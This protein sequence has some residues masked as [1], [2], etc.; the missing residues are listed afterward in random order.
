MLTLMMKTDRQG[1]EQVKVGIIDVR[2]EFTPDDTDA[3]VTFCVLKRIDMLTGFFGKCGFVSEL[4]RKANAI[5]S[6]PMYQAVG[7]GPNRW[8]N[9]VEVWFHPTF[10]LFF[11][12][13]TRTEI[14]GDIPMFPRTL[15]L[16]WDIWNDMLS[17]NQMP[18]WPENSRGWSTWASSK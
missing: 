1:M 11:R 16:G 7:W 3:A 9:P 15:H 2:C 17:K 12:Y 6:L 18:H 10:W 8:G 4:A 14:L 13:Y 5:C